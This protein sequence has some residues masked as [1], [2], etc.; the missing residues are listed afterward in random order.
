[1]QGCWG[2]YWGSG[3]SLV[4][5]FSLTGESCLG[6]TRTLAESESDFGH[7]RLETCHSFQPAGSASMHPWPSNSKLIQ[8]ECKNPSEVAPSSSVNG[9]A[10]KAD[11]MRSNSPASDRDMRAK[12]LID[13]FN[14]ISSKSEKPDVVPLPLYDPKGL[15]E[16]ARSHVGRSVWTVSCMG[17]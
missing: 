11:T 7:F 4:D 3:V 14:S 8:L 9:E 13:K 1:M 2:Q 16:R 5:G 15:E 17:T 6:A 12:Q 10:L